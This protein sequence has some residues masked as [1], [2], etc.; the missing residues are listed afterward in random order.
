M[1]FM[2]SGGSAPASD[3]VSV[4]VPDTAGSTGKVNDGA[5]GNNNLTKGAANNGVT[6]AEELTQ[7]A[8][9]KKTENTPMANSLAI[10]TK[11]YRTS[12]NVGLGIN[13]GAPSTGLA[14]IK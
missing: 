2:S 14:G 4:T 7:T 5:T 13:T 12:K 6:P 9:R 1:C 10:G 8:P 3:P 11:R